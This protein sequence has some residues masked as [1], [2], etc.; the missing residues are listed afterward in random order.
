MR[1]VGAAERVFELLDRKPKLNITGGV[2][3]PQ[4]NGTIALSHVTFRYPS[5]PKTAVLKDVSFVLSPGQVLALVGPSGCG[6]TTIAQLLL[7]FY[8]VNAGSVSVDGKNVNELEPQ[9]WR[10]QIGYVG[11]DSTLFAMVSIRFDSLP[12]AACCVL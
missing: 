12:L 3:L 7:R 10:A 6:K 1:A 9:W 8:D 4:L 5:R 11:Q 2:T